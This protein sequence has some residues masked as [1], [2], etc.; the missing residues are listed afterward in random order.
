MG[1]KRKQ[2][3]SQKYKPEDAPIIYED[4]VDA[5]K[6]AVVST[7]VAESSGETVNIGE[8]VASE[9]VVQEKSPKT[10]TENVDNKETDQEP[11]ITCSFSDDFLNKT[12]VSVKIIGDKSGRNGT[13]AMC[14]ANIAKIVVTNTDIDR[15]ILVTKKTAEAVYDLIVD[16][17]DKIG[18]A[19]MSRE[20]RVMIAEKFWSNLLRY[21][22]I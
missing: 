17:P 4:S 13:H 14:I 8:Q 7:N 6:T 21:R 15:I 19:E 2:H 18:I 9:K 20:A 5:K 16:Y 22:A 3:T 1:N 11:K 10:T 12:L